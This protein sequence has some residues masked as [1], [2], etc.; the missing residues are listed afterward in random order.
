MQIEQWFPIHIGFAH[1]PFHKEIEDELTRQC[2]KIKKSYKKDFEEFRKISMKNDSQSPLL[3]WFKFQSNGSY[4]LLEDQ[5]FDKLH[6]WIDNQ[7]RE[8]AETLGFVDKLKCEAGWFNI[9]EKYE[10]ADYHHHRPSALSCVY[11]LNCEENAGAKLFIRN[12][13]DALIHY[14]DDPNFDA[15]GPN[16]T[17]KSSIIPLMYHDPFPGKLVVFSSHLEHA[18]QQHNTDN[19]RITLSYN[20]NDYK[21]YK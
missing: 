2:V 11:F 1:N 4:K 13:N 3:D 6:N 20:Y 12:S 10:Y 8:F 14:C 16:S 5:K 7:I 17:T 18:V 9:Y 21:V 19:L 15:N